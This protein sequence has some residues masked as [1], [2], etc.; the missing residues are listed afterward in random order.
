MTPGTEPIVAEA[1]GM[2]ADQAHDLSLAPTPNPLHKLHSY[3]RGR[4]TWMVLLSL[5]LATGGGALG[6][7]AWQ[8][9]YQSIGLIQVQPTVPR[10][11]YTT[12]DNN[13][14]QI[15]DNYMQNQIALLMSR[16][17]TDMAMADKDW[18]KLGRGVSDAAIQEFA[19]SLSVQRDAR[20]PNI[21]ILFQN[22]D[23]LVA[24]AGT[25][26]VINAYEELY[27]EQNKAF[28]TYR[29]RVIEGVIA[30]ADMHIKDFRKLIFEKAKEYGSTSLDEVYSH[31]LLQQQT[32]D[33][34]LAEMDMQMDTLAVIA[35]RKPEQPAHRDLASF[36]IARVNRTME[37]HL[38]KQ[39]E[40]Q[41]ALRVAKINHT[42]IHPTVRNIQQ[43]LNEINKLIEEYTREHNDA[44]RQAA[45][46]QYSNEDRI[47]ARR[48]LQELVERRLTLNRRFKRAQEETLRIGKTNL[49]IRNLEDE[50]ETA[51]KQLA[52][53]SERL[54]ALRI[55]S[56]SVGGRI[57]I[58]SKGDHPIAPINSGRQT[59][60]MLL[61]VMAGSSLGVGI[62]ILIGASDR[63]YRYIEDTYDT[64]GHLRMLGVLPRLPADLADPAQASIAAHAVQQIR[65]MLQLAYIDNPQRVFSVTSGT[66]GDGKT[67]LTMAL[68]LSFAASG[69]RTLLIDFDLSGRGLSEQAQ[70]VVRRRIGHVLLKEGRISEP[71]LA[72]GLHLAT[73]SSCRLGEALVQL[74]FMNEDDVAQALDLQAESIVGLPQVLDGEDL[75]NC[76]KA[77]ETPLL[78]ILPIGDGSVELAGSLSPASI[79]RLLDQTRRH[80]NAI[81]IDTG[82]MPASIEGSLVASQV[83]G[84]IFVV[85]R[86]VQQNTARRAMSHLVSLGANVAGLVFNR[87]NPRDMDSYGSSSGQGLSSRPA[88]QNQPFPVPDDQPAPSRFGPIAQ[89]TARCL[90][91]ADDRQQRNN[92]DDKAT[93]SGN[94][95]RDTD[96]ENHD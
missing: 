11:L 44:M 93:H 13:L 8:P 77:T 78:S 34:Q 88:S 15:F 86:G 7:F 56:A 61:G 71:Q 64:M 38:Q 23:P 65:T 47:N 59:L 6:W 63:R 60:Y 2:I 36:E 83:D 22:T 3:L 90:P 30:K 14:S 45:A 37:L 40:L 39:G 96:A 72:E 62:F 50:I 19:N 70:A 58:L 68:G 35:S 80:Y 73:Q 29:T 4:Y 16:R 41:L 95:R 51:K 21:Y 5:V 10:I 53:A 33:A 32:L 28:G 54:E 67:S 1:T 94:S 85:S 17:V 27:K 18:Q 9:M 76:V 43:H 52:D 84:V 57:N 55:E 69:A 79:G 46:Q 25:T 81:L 91:H 82:P 92:A 12:E 74:G 24:T 66:S 31:K 42:D 20:N 49:E 75:E 89:A 87:A 26:A 48:G